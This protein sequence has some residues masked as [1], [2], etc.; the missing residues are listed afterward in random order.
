MSN[1]L[2]PAQTE[3]LEK[4]RREEDK[5]ILELEDF[6]KENNVPILNWNAAELLEQLIKIK[7]P[8]KVLEIGTAIG[9]STIRIAKNLIDNSII[10]TIDFSQDAISIAK[11]NFE[12]S[13]MDSKIKQL[14]GNAL[15]I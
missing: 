9:Y 2:C 4:I 1:I 13:G 7:S 15:Q 6:A 12:K 5:L 3:Y 11:I 8:K 10:E 14:E